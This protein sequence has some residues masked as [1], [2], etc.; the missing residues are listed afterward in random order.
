MKKRLDK[1]L[2]EKGLFQSRHKAQA[3]IIEGKVLVDEVKITKS[4][5]QVKPNVEINVIKD[6]NRYV[7]RGGLK[8]EKAL[9]S[10]KIDVKDKMVADIGASTGGFTDC[11]LQ[12]GAKKVLSIDVGYGQFSYRLRNDQRVVLWERTNI[13]KIDLDKLPFLAEFVAVDL[14]FISFEKVV[15]KILELSA[16]NAEMLILVKPQFEAGPSKIGKGGIVR[17][18][19]VHY[20]VLDNFQEVCQQYKLFFSGL[21][22]SPIR[23]NKGNI[24]YLSLINRE[25]KIN[26]VKK[27]TIRRIVDNAFLKFG[28]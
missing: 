25:N 7:S 8:L 27:R 5:F 23:G 14:S 13:R 28:G 6:D 21:I 18:K 15:E 1:V 20:E 4:G 22:S 11:L 10:F 3:A 16:K 17:D 2:V 26:Q 24:E 9:Y 19:N 12:H